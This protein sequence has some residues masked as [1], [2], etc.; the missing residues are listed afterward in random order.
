[1]KKRNANK[2]KQQKWLENRRPKS[3]AERNLDGFCEGGDLANL[4]QTILAHYKK[5]FVDDVEV[6]PMVCPVYEI[7]MKD[8]A[9]RPLHINVA[10][11]MPYTLRDGAKAQLDRLFA[12]GIFR[13]LK[14]ARRNN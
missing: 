4:F 6:K 1:M 7:E 3:L 5:V 14:E 11:K 8:K 12:K 10:Q 2:I 9:I 13:W